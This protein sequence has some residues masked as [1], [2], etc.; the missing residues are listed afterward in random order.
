MSDDEEFEEQL[1]QEKLEAL[2]GS[3]VNEVIEH[4]R[5]RTDEDGVEF[6][7]DAHKRA[8]FPKVWRLTSCPIRLT[9]HYVLYTSL[10]SYSHAKLDVGYISDIYFLSFH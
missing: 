8:W 1:K 3:E 9:M 7:W 2:Q 5:T 6:E 4:G 10:R